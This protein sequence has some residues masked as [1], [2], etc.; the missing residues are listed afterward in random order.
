MELSTMQ[1]IK[2]R[3][4]QAELDQDKAAIDKL[5]AALVA[6]LYLLKASKPEDRSEKARRFAVC[7]T[8]YEKMLSYFNTMIREDFEG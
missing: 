6:T 1:E 7:I 4:Y 2:L 3:E 8:D 5:W